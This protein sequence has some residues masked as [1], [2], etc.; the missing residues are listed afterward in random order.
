MYGNVFP[1]LSLIIS[2]K[3]VVTPIFVLEFEAPSLKEQGCTVI[4]TDKADNNASFTF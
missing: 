2:E 1:Y 3:C 4:P